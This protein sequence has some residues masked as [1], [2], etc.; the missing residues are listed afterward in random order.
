MQCWHEQGTGS[1]VNRPVARS[2]SALRFGL[3]ELHVTKPD[4][5]IVA[6]DK[7]RHFVWVPLDPKPAILPSRDAICIASTVNRIP[8]NEPQPSRSNAMPAPPS[9]GHAAHN[10]ADT[11]AIGQRSQSIVDLIAEA[12]ELRTVVLDASSRLS[13]LLT[14]LKQH[15]RQS[16]AVQAAMQSLKQLKLDG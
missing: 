16:R 15:R 13:R 8:S 6:R 1:P 9:N 3:T 10:T 7:Q 4:V 11:S 14:G 5:P 12:E 2:E